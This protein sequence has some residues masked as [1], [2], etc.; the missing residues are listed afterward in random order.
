MNGWPVEITGQ[1]RVPLTGG[2]AMFPNDHQPQH[3][4]ERDGVTRLS[5]WLICF[6]TETGWYP[7]GEFIALDAAAAI[8]RAVD[9]FGPGLDYQA[10][11]IPWDTAPLP[12]A[13]PPCDR[14][15]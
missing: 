8:E 7:V 14:K 2:A 1:L 3:Q 9:V 13:V 15:C 4:E 12:R 5:R 10:E 11:E 6:A